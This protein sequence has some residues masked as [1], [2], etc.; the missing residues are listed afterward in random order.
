MRLRISAL[1]KPSRES[2]LVSSISSGKRK[3]KEPREPRTIF[4]AV[5]PLIPADIELPAT[6][7]TIPEHVSADRIN[8]RVT[9]AFSGVDAIAAVPVQAGGQIFRLGDIATVKRGWGGRLQ[10]DRPEVVQA[11]KPISQAE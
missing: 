5:T 8:L 9:G 1:P 3:T 10:S 4:S 2:A 6:L 11:L 7:S